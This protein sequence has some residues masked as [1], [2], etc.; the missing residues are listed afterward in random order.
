MKLSFLGRLYN[1]LKCFFKRFSAFIR[2]YFLSGF[3][4]A[5]RLRTFVFRRFFLCSHA[6]FLV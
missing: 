2:A 5:F 4:E 1:S 3:Y 6:G